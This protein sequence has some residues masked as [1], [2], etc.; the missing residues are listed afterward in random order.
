MSKKIKKEVI[1]PKVKETKNKTFVIKGFLC[2][3][4]I[5]D[6][7]IK[8]TR[9]FTI[10]AKEKPEIGTIFSVWAHAKLAYIKTT[11]VLDTYEYL[12]ESNNFIP[13]NKVRPVICEINTDNYKQIKQDKDRK[14]KFKQILKERIEEKKL[15]KEFSDTLKSINVDDDIRQILKELI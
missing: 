1:L 11:E 5:K 13:L 9:F 12:S 15:E 8:E 3:H 14:D 10:L 2:N 4:T 6:P 7:E